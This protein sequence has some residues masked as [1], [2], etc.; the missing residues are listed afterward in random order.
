M[1]VFSCRATDPEG[2]AAIESWLTVKGIK[3]DGVTNEKP[4]ADFYLD[5]KAIRFTTWADFMAAWPS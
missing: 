4:H 1:V 2:K 5:D 3:V